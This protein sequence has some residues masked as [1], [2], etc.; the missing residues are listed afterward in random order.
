MKINAPSLGDLILQEKPYISD[1]A[2]ALKLIE[3]V[4]CIELHAHTYAF[5]LN[6]QHGTF[7]IF[8]LCDFA[9]ENNLEGVSIHIDAGNEKSISNYSPK[10]LG[11]LRNYLESHHLN[12]SI[13]ASSTSKKVI[14]RSVYLANSLGSKNIRVYDRYKGQL[15][16]IIQKCIK[17]MKDVARIAEKHDLHFVVEPH[18]V[19][20]SAELV[21]IIEAVKSHRVNLLFDF[22]NMLST[23]EQPLHALE[24]MHP[25]IKQVHLKGANIAAVGQ[26]GFAQIGVRQG[27]DDLPHELM[28]FKL[29]MLGESKPQVG[30]LSLE[31]QVGYYGPPYRFENESPNPVI[32]KRKPSKTKL[33]PKLTLD[34]NLN[35]ELH[36]AYHQVAFVNKTLENLTNL[37]SKKLRKKLMVA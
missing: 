24:T 35:F 14:S 36:N 32:P 3:R 25:Y 20:K 6:L 22:G 27:D 1:S 8:D 31:Q 10:Q 33:Y 12:I 37:A 17:R 26:N 11:K 34:E 19:L 9:S 7:D 28:F 4:E 5:Y 2:E 16:D 15:S 23:A 18:E 13:E 21:H 29:L 30:V